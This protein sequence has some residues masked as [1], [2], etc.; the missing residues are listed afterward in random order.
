MAEAGPLLTLLFR[1]GVAELVRGKEKSSERKGEAFI[2]F[3]V[4]LS[5]DRLCCEFEGTAD[6][7]V[8]GLQK[9]G[10]SAT[11]ARSVDDV[12]GAK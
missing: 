2:G 1:S 3:L 11:I 10:C 5:N 7:D 8:L 9:L 4:G 12:A 6:S